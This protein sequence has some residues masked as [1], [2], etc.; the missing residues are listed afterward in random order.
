M[1]TADQAALRLPNESSDTVGLDSR[2]RRPEEG[3][4]DPAH[5]GY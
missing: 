1:P 4:E 2:I 3:A 5:A